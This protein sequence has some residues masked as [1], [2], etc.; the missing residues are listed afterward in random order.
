MSF[1]YCTR[2]S[3][4]SLEQ[5]SQAEAPNRHQILQG[6]PE[7]LELSWGEAMH[8]SQYS[9]MLLYRLTI[10]AKMDKPWCMYGL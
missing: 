10:V 3:V 9:V 2:L 6:K 7:L 5:C 8:A 4:K 1:P